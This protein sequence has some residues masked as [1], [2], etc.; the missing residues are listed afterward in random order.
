MCLCCQA[1][2]CHDQRERSS[3]GTFEYMQHAI[4]FKEMGI[5]QTEKRNASHSS[6]CCRGIT[7]LIAQLMMTENQCHV[8]GN[9]V[10]G[11]DDEDDDN[12]DVNKDDG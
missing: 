2:A 11:N 10:D 6:S 4:R 8:D 1:H 5:N 3:N 9:D 12:D 7:H